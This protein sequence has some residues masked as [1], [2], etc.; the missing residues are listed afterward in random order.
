MPSWCGHRHA[1]RGIQMQETKTVKTIR[2]PK[3]QEQLGV[4]RSTI[5]RWERDGKFPKHIQLGENSTAWIQEEVDAWVES[6][7]QGGENENL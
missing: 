7:R 5:F 4:S 2:F 1:L 3:L 6:R